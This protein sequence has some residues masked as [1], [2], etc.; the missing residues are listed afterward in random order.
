M[1]STSLVVLLIAHLFGDFYFQ[2][3]WIVRG[4][5]NLKPLPHIIH[6]AIH[7][8]CAF[9]A[10]WVF[11]EWWIALIVSLCV[12]ISHLGVDYLKSFVEPRCKRTLFKI[13]VFVSDQLIHVITLIVASRFLVHYSFST[14]SICNAIYGWFGFTLPAGKLLFYIFALLFLIQPSNVM[15]RHILDVIFK[16]NGIDKKKE[17]SDANAGVVI[18]IL[19]RL[20]MYCFS[21]FLGWHYIIIVVLTAKTF[22]RLNRFG[23]KEKKDNGVGDF[24]AEKYIVGTL[25]SVLYVSVCL[26]LGS[27]VN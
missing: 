15:N 27:F 24:F 16:D 26:V 20:T 18:G 8:V 14:N 2:P 12:A 10:S 6:V 3:K 11:V 19:E 13:L 17:A 5:E 1:I 23:S 4:K 25:L 9:L 22:T 21:A 7:F